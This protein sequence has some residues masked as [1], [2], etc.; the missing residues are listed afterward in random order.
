MPKTRRIHPAKESN[1]HETQGR[2]YSNGKPL[3]LYVGDL[4]PEKGVE[5]NE[6]VKP[7]KRERR[8][9]GAFMR[10]Y[11]LEGLFSVWTFKTIDFLGILQTKI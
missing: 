10:K 6:N 11:F 7:Q 1:T 4:E 8:S 9:F 5:L 2:N 3:Q